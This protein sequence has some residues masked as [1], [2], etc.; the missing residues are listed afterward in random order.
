[1]T[2]GAD[3]TVSVQLAGQA[4]P[5]QI[6]ALTLADFVNPAGLQA[7]GENLF[8]ETGASGPA[9]TGGPGT[10]GPGNGGPG[11]GGPGN[12]DGNGGPFD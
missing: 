8:A 4:Q 11:N 9:Q 2:I 6:G 10:G 12:G 1:M 7:L 3:G 5:V